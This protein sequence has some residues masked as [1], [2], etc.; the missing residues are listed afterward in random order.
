MSEPD[1]ASPAPRAD[2]P[3]R[4][5]APRKPLP[6]ALPADP[7]DAEWEKL[8]RE[9]VEEEIDEAEEDLA[10]AL[11]EP[12]EPPSRSKWMWGA[13]GI[14]LVAGAAFAAWVNLRLVA[15]PPPPPK[16]ALREGSGAP[17][18]SELGPGVGLG[19]DADA[20]A[21]PE[22]EPDPAA[23]ADPQP[24]VGDAGASR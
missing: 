24:A 11:S 1:P 20:D 6:G 16:D 18:P 13:F 17:S 23:D 8:E 21:E 3:A 2:T 9:R 4:P 5:G 14:A 10:E 7:V 15:S 22:E 19:A 12:Q